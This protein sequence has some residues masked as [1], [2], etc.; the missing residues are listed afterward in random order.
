MNAQN[1][2]YLQIKMLC[3]RISLEKSSRAQDK[4]LLRS[5]LYHD[6]VSMWLQRSHMP[7]DDP[8]YFGWGLRDK[9]GAWLLIWMSSESSL[10]LIGI[11]G[12]RYSKCQMVAT[13]ERPALLHGWDTFWNSVSCKLGFQMY[14]CLD[15]KC[16]QKGYTQP[17]TW[18]MSM[19]QMQYFCHWS[20]TTYPRRKS[21][22][23]E[24]LSWLQCHNN[25]FS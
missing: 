9:W 16:Y 10:H 21:M 17:S 18:G 11:C 15:S 12:H 22:C 2:C 5:Y 24:A 14:N 1:F 7:R 3:C 23:S 19:F 20:I 8:S 13:V 6:Q 4:S 25:V